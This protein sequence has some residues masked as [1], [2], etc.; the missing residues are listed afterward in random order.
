MSMIDFLFAIIFYFLIFLYFLK[1]RKRIEVQSKVFFLLKSKR[2][3]N[4]LTKYGKKFSRFW[5]IYGTISIFIVMVSLILMTTFVFLNLFNLVFN[6]SIASKVSIV[7]PGIQIPGSPIYVP[8]LYGIIS[9][10]VIILVHES[11]HAFVVASKKL[12]IKSTGVGFF[13]FLPL[14]FVE[15]DEEKFKK[16]K[17]LDRAKIAAV[18]PTTNILFFFIILLIASII[19]TPMLQTHVIQNGVMILDVNKNSPAYNANISSGEKV[20]RINNIFIQNITDITNLFNNE[21]K[22]GQTI[23]FITDK[24]EYNVTLSTKPENSSLPYVG[25]LFVQDYKILDNDIVGLIFFA[26]WNLLFWLANLNLW[27]GLMNTLPVSFFDGGVVFKGLL[28]YLLKDDKKTTKIIGFLSYFVFLILI[29][30][31]FLSYTL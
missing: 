13:L 29:L 14:A 23:T 5:N 15:P 19:V 22:P 12:K 28:D 25:L 1:N 7:I 16:L 11:A 6:P 3:V 20:L 21:L 10:F 2:G 9:L 17:P 24:G 8:F 26:I 4:F 31:L 27:V 30:S 18:G